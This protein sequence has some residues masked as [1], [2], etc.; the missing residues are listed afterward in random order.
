MNQNYN[1]LSWRM[2]TTLKSGVGMDVGSP[3]SSSTKSGFTSWLVSLVLLVCCLFGGN[4]AMAQVS[5]Y[6]FSQGTSSF[7]LLTGAVAGGGAILG[8]AT[9]NTTGGSLDDT[10]FT[11]GTFPFTFTFNGIGYTTCRV[12]TNGFITFGTTAP[13]SSGSTTGYAPISAST[14]YAGAV[15]AWGMD[16]NSFF[17]LGGRTGEI[18]WDVVGTAPNREIVIQ[19]KDLRPTFDTSTTSAYGT[20]IQIRLQETTNNVIIHYGPGSYAVGSTAASGLPQ[21]GLRGAANTDFLNRTNAAGVLFT[22]STAGGS[23][24]ATQSGNS[25]A[26]PPGMPSNGMTYTYTPPTPCNSTP[27]PGS[28]APLAVNI[29]PG[30]TQAFTVTGSQTGVSGLTFQWEVSTDG[31]SNWS[32]AGGTSTNAGYTTP[33]YVA[34]SG[35]QLYRR[36]TICLAASAS[37]VTNSVSVSGQV[38]PTTQI[39]NF[40]VSASTATSITLTW[41]AGNGNNRSIFISDS[42]SFTNPTDNTSPGTASTVYTAPGQKLVYDG[43]ASTVTVTG[44]VAGT[45]YYFRAYES[46]KCTSPAYY[47]NTTGT[48]ISSAPADKLKYTIARSSTTYTPVSGTATT[49]NSTTANADDTNYGQ[50]SFFPFTYAG[51]TFNTFRVCTNG[52]MTLNAGNTSTTFNNGLTASTSNNYVLAPFWED[53]FVNNVSTPN[54]QF[55]KYEVTGSAPNRVLTV[56]WENLELFNYPG[57]SLNF[58]VKLYETTNVIEYVYGVMQG[59]DGTNPVNATVTNGL[60]YNYTIGMVAGT[61]ATPAAAGDVMGLQ[62]ANSLSFTSLGGIMTNEGINKLSV[63][64]D[65]NSKYTF[66]PAGS[67]RANDPQPAVPGPPSNDDPAGAITLTPLPTTP[68]NLCGS[69]YSSAFATATTGVAAPIASTNAD[70]DVWFKFNA[71][72]TNTTISLRGAGGYDAAM[73]LFNGTTDPTFTTPVASKNAN[74]MTGTSLTETING[75]DVSTVIGNDY[76]VRVYHTGGGTTATVNATVSGGV[77]TGFTG[78]VGGSGYVTCYGGNGLTATPF[79]YITD[80]T[81]S[82]AVAK[83]TVTGGAISA[84]ALQSSQGGTGYSATPTVKIAAPG[85]GVTGD[86]SIIVNATP[87]APANDAICNATPLS[88]S[89]TCTT[90]SGTTQ[91][92]TASPEAGCGGVSDDDVYYSFVAPTAN[93]T[94]TVTPGAAGFN[95]IVQIFSS[96]NNLCSGTLTT[97]ACQN[98]GVGG[99]AEVV[100]TSGLIPGNTY[101]VRVYH[102]LSGYGTGNFTICVTGSA[103]SCLSG[104]TAP[105]D[106]GSTCD[107]ASVTLTWPAGGTS[108]NLVVDGVPFNGLTTT[109]YT[110]ASP[111]ALGPHTWSVTPVNAIGA[112]SGCPTW[113]F[114]VVPSATAGTISGP[115]SLPVNAV[116]SYSENGT[117]GS[118]FQWKSSTVSGGPYTNIASA[119]TNPAN[120]SFSATGVYYVVFARSISGCADVVSSE[121]AITVTAASCPGSLGV[122]SVTVGSIP[123]T[124]SGQTTCGSGNNL[125]STNVVCVPTG[126]GN[127]FGGQDRTY[128]FTPTVTGVHTIL[129]TTSTDDDAGIML[130]EGCPFTVG[131]TCLTSAIGT[132]GL[133]RTINQ[134]LTAGITYYLVVDNFPSPACVGTYSLSITPPPTCGVPTGLATTD[135]AAGTSVDIAW[136]APSLGTAATYDWEI[137]TS[138][139]GGSGATG[140]INSGNTASTSV[141][142][143]PG[144]SANVTYSLYVRTNC[145]GA[146]GSSTWAGPQSFTTPNSCPTGLGVNRVL[147]PSIPYA[148]TA[149]TTCGSGNNVTSS[150]VTCVT[151]STNYYGGEDRTY[152]FTPT[153]TGMHTILLTTTSD[154]DA[155]IQLYAGCPFT[156]GST[157][158]GNVQASTGLTRTMTPTLT[159]GVTYYLVVDNWIAPA[160]IAG[161]DL[162][163]DGPPTCGTPSAL[164]VSDLTLTTADIS[165]T[166]QTIGTATNYDWEIRTSGAGGS[167]ATGL[168]TSGTTAATSV[169]DVPGLT[170]NVAYSLYVRTNCTGTD[171]SSNWAGPTTFTLTEGESCATAGTVVVAASLAAAPDTILSTGVSSDGPAGTCSDATGNPSKKD[172]WVKFVAPANGNKVVITTIGGSLT[173]FVMQVWD[174]CP[175]VAGNA[176]GCS[177][178]FNSLMPELSFCSLTPGATYYV[179]VWPYSATSTGTFNI[180]IYEDVACPLPPANDN[181]SGVVTLTVGA[182]GTCPAN[183]VAGTTINAQPSPGVVKNSC[184]LF[185]TYYDVFYKF[186]SGANTSLNYKFT[187]L[188]GT[189]LI[190]FGLYTACGSVY[191][192]SCNDASVAGTTGTWTGLTPNTDYYVI[193]YSTTV[194]NQGDFTFCVSELPII[195]SVAP[196]SITS[197]AAGNT[198]CGPGNVNFTVTGGS[199]GTGASWKLYRGGCGTEGGGTLVATSS[200][201]TFANVSIPSSGTYYVRAEGTGN[202]T[203]CA[204]VSMTVGTLVTYYFDNDGDGVGSTIPEDSQTSCN[205]LTGLG[206][207]TTTGDCDDS[208]PD[209]SSPLT[210][211]V[212]LASNDADNT[213]CAGTSVTFTATASSLSGL[214]DGDYYGTGPVVVTYAFKVGATTVQTSTSNTFTTSGL[215]N[216]QS[217]SVVISVTGG[218]CRTTD[219]ATSNSITNTV[220]GV[221]EI[222]WNGILENCSTTLSQGCTPV[223]VNMTPSYNGTTLTSLATAIPAVPYTYS[224]FTNLKYRFSITNVTTGAVSADIIQTSRYVTI[225]A[226]LHT[227][228]AQYTIKASAVINEE[229]VPFAGNTIT[230]FS[231][232]VQLI[233]LNTASCGATLA[234][235]SSTLTANQGLNATGYTFRIRLNDANPSPTYATSQ[236]ATRF[237]GANTFTGFPLQYGTSYKV[238]VQYTF[239]DPVSNL[240]VQ[241]GY[242]AECTVN[243]PSIPLTTM[244]SPTCG[245]QVSTLNANISATAASYATGYQFRI[246]LFADNG[247]TPAYTYSAVS[248]SRFSSLTAF[249]TLAYNTAYSISVQ[250]SILNGSTTVWSGY[251]PECKVTTPFFPTTSLVPSQCGLVAATPLTQQ[252]N[253]T[254]YPG[255][256]HYKVLLEEVSGEDVLNSQEREIVYSYFK[257]NEFSIAQPGKNYQVS[258]AIKL[259]G[260]FGDYSTACDLH[261]PPAA[262][263][264]MAIPFKAT[265]YPN[266]F[267]NN[268]ML[269]VKSSSE[270]N[271]NIKVYDMIGRLIE[272]RDVRVSDMQTTTI[273]NQYPAGVYNVV[274]SQEDSVETV[275]VVKR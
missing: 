253:I 221:A 165:W 42:N 199:L 114:N 51:S 88:V 227:H 222:C 117:G 11:T 209:V 263:A 70:D 232:S 247:P 103:P 69:F 8:T 252:L 49:V 243:T 110:P 67:I 21:I 159:A 157:C 52:F 248:A 257:L 26:S 28:A 210:P 234:S 245:T 46:N 9:A 90:T 237:V 4:G 39:S 166:A 97:V 230:V 107:S 198:I 261:T 18:R 96:S 17:S 33:A 195:P 6:G 100:S 111:F 177:D 262:K 228:G 206:Y 224:T 246:R 84:V 43:T 179:Q 112:A 85:Y 161:Y 259:N 260:V 73:Q 138:G 130:Y 3:P 127:Y 55:I 146:D 178:D 163:I 205:D 45:T 38:G 115:S 172:R 95:P 22:A 186:N 41:T 134:A 168:Q 76:Y 271:V 104:P 125:T 215:T 231:P 155:G 219:N 147:V 92:A 244:A 131:S 212:T 56:Q 15:S 201:A 273:G 62:Q 235:L 194:A 258:V 184:D 160:C 137:R 116:G 181:C 93:P 16:T 193:V 142:D 264:E 151:G 74:S 57:P 266:P 154:D 174:S 128:I 132:T 89:G 109:S 213:F 54:S 145:T 77:I 226:A 256:P 249:G 105:A 24:S 30:S 48:S 202:N 173:D 153:Q 269:D 91:N 150:N 175:A 229:I 5:N 34:G 176:L 148:T 79:V 188:S 217:V 183:E 60:A 144:L 236:S 139:A 20:N 242:G 78:L 149:Q 64:P 143:V 120:L 81:G 182:D 192:G 265:A 197:S 106:G 2:D 204:S 86:F 267:A 141:N 272:Q 80:A 35:T 47:Y 185:A 233:T 164:T 1:P 200:T 44:L 98:N 158:V 68:A 152:I 13:A 171:G 218:T 196:T 254:P 136:T 102:A 58:Q 66:T 25:T 71:I 53:L 214:N 140:L 124:T 180:K 19:W 23:N 240:P 191:S 238:S 268:F 241:S 7:N 31:G 118:T 65:C 99:E 122:N 87:E 37:D 169:N 126:S 75:T 189:G 250:Y 32:N 27:A 101:F 162:T 170:V 123:Y 108:Y 187:D 225:P 156:T 61:W 63:L 190:T 36:R 223:V 270:S 10:I 167:G 207:V 129:L 14:G 50:F 274:V 83:V 275:R 255:F 113:T 220:N 203:T 72:S 29:C 119:T 40:S 216:G 208:D 121:F 12:S 94:V 133:T 59:F 211:Q 135:F 251:G 82:G 239:T